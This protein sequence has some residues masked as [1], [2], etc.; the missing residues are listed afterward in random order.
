[1][2]ETSL[3]QEKDL[4]ISDPGIKN[5]DISIKTTKDMG[6]RGIGVGEAQSTVN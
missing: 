2:V 3:F 5:K 6:D 1:M 4:Y